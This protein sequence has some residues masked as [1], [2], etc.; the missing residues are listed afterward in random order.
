VAG[1]QQVSA[2]EAYTC[3][4]DS[5]GDITCWGD[6]S[7]AQ[8]D[9]S[10]TMYLTSAATVQVASGSSVDPG[11]Q[12]SAASHHTCGLLKNAPTL[13]CWGT[14]TNFEVAAGATSPADPTGQTGTFVWVAAGHDHSCGVSVGQVVCW[15]LNTS[16]QTG[17]PST[18]ST[19]AQPTSLTGGSAISVT[20]GYA[21]TCAQDNAGDAYCWGSNQFGQLGNATPTN[22][23]ANPNP[24]RVTLGSVEQLSA[25]HDHACAVLGAPP[26]GG[27]PQPGPVYCW[28]SNASGQLGDGTTATLRTSPVPVG[29]PTP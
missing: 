6:N 16:G 2:G 17:G 20:A 14:N 10:G 13:A 9:T 25:G 1:V 19:S 23:T 18:T 5:G 12:V 15:G 24:S 8:I 7:S 29:L 4:V 22:T 3:A 26:N 28:G 27:M 11:L 21:F